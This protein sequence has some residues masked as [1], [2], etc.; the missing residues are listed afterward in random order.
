MRGIERATA[1]AVRYRV[2]VAAGILLLLTTGSVPSTF[3]ADRSGSI[4]F[5]WALVYKD[6][7]GIIKPIDYDK[8]VTRLDSGD[9]FKFYFKPLS[10]CH[11]YLY[12]FD[13]QK[14][15]FL[16]FP[17]DFDVVPDAARIT[18]NY[19]LPGVNSWFYLDEKSGLEVFYLI[20][21]ARPLEELE[22]R[23][24]RYLERYGDPKTNAGEIT[25]KHGVLDEI[26]RIIKKSS[27]LSD[28]AEKPIAVAG[29]FRGVREEGELNGVRIEATDIYVKTI[30]LQH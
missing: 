15:L 30:R 13:A 8:T 16:L 7:G 1:R 10:S 25:S 12:L 27:Y 21:S 29:D 2:A 26:K 5:S 28:A 20:V 18:R 11:I 6:D 3:A 14:N 23:T 19:D 22:N 24:K 4:S 9:K 17:E